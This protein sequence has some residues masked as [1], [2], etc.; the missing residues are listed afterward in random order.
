MES[1]FGENSNLLTKIGVLG[2]GLGSIYNDIEQ[3]K[4]LLGIKDTYNNTFEQD[5]AAAYEALSEYLGYRPE[6]VSGA[7]SYRSGYGE[8]PT[9]RDRNGNYY[10]Y[11]FDSGSYGFGPY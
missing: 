5:W 10:S 9:Y 1:F 4:G 2:S 6:Q 11:N 7:S 3:I 8:A